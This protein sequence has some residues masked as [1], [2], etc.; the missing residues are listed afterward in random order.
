M[1]AGPVDLEVELRCQP[2]AGQ[3][4][5][6]VA[7]GGSRFRLENL[8]SGLCSQ[9]PAIAGPASKGKGDQVAF[10]TFKGSGTGRLNNVAGAS[11]TWTLTDQGEPGKNDTVA[12]QIKDRNNVVVLNASGRLASGNYQAHK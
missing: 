6:D 3:N 4:N 10:N 8:T 7:W 9:D 2:S 5:L 12:I 11:A 1:P